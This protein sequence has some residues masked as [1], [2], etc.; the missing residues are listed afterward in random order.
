[1]N[2]KIIKYAIGNLLTILSYLMLIPLL[3]S[4]IYQEGFRKYAKLYN[5]NYNIFFYWDFP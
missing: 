1:M 2:T 4:V 3:V 5:S